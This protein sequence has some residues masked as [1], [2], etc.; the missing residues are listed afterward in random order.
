M[1]AGPRRASIG[2]R[3]AYTIDILRILHGNVHPRYEYTGDGGGGRGG[4]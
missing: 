3:W 2:M 1:K 4:T